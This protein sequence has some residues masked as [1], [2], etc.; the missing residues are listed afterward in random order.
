MADQLDSLLSE[1]FK[2]DV[3]LIKTLPKEVKS[4]MDAIS[5]ANESSKSVE[6]SRA[7]SLRD[8]KDGTRAL[9]EEEKKRLAL[10][11]EYT[12]QLSEAAKEEALLAVQVNEL[13]KANVEAAKAI[14]G[15]GKSSREAAAAKKA[16]REETR[17]LREEKKKEEQQRRYNIQ[18][19]KQEAKEI[20][21][22]NKYMV[23][24]AKAAE[25]NNDAFKKLGQE[26]KKLEVSA[27]QLGAIYGP[28]DQRFLDAAAAANLYK[29]RIN[30][31]NVALGDHRHN[32]GNYASGLVS[33][34]QLLR[35]MPNIGISVQTFIM[36]LSNQIGQVT[37][38]IKKLRIQN[39]EL[40]A[41]GKAAIPVWKSFLSSLMSWQTAIMIAATAVIAYREEI[42]DFFSEM[43]KGKKAI[44]SVASAMESLTKSE[45]AFVEASKQLADLTENVRLAKDGLIDK[46]R[47]LRIYNEGLGK[48]MGNLTNFADLEKRITEAGPAYIQMMLMRAAAHQA[49]EEAAKKAFEAEQTRRKPLNEMGGFWSEIKDDL[50]GE[51][52]DRKA[53]DIS[54]QSAQR[55][56]RERIAKE[57]DDQ[58]NAL[59][60]IA[61]KFNKD[62]EV[63]AAKMKFDPLGG[64]GIEKAKKPKSNKAYERFVENWRITLKEL[65]NK[66]KNGEFDVDM[67]NGGDGIVLEAHIRLKESE[68]EQ[69]LKDIDNLL[70]QKLTAIH[71]KYNRGGFKTQEDYEKELLR[72]TTEYSLKR[73]GV[74]IENSK[75]MMALLDPQSEEYKAYYKKLGELDK[76]YQEEIVKGNKKTTAETQKE[77][78][79]RLN[80][81][82]DM[83][84][85]SMALNNEIQA[86]GD[87]FFQKKIEALEHEGE[88]IDK[89]LERELRSIRATTQAGTERDRLTRAAEAR[90]DAERKK[91]DAEV[92]RMKRRQAMF[93]RAA[94]IA[95]I[96][97]KTALA[98]VTALTEG[99]P[100]TKTF[101][102]IAAGV[103]GAAQLARAIATPLP[104]YAEGTQN[105]KGGRALIGEGGEKELVQEPGGKTWIADRPMI[106]NL[107][108]G[109]RVIPEHD[110]VA[111]GMGLLTPNLIG[112][113]TQ[114]QVSEIELSPKTVKAIGRAVSHSSKQSVN[115]Y[116]VDVYRLKHVKGRA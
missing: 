93:D 27:R 43:F 42:A 31:I 115:I 78:E 40:I 108:A 50:F 81:I 104:S 11:F 57:A 41:Q 79:T 99:D 102:A 36:S 80:R 19:E 38:D 10:Q 70:N 3:E 48:T 74:Q 85:A 89:N 56:R 18:L 49:L 62:A 58:K 71:E 30:E 20:A 46:D 61:D 110:L 29:N 63:I 4:L 13:K 84:G 69:E 77:L 94:N 8:V 101:R 88:L 55:R 33:T 60:D 54:R 72:V 15:V 37:D 12:H 67:L 83:I 22:L 26:H 16:E 7:K 45:G 52:K 95:E 98:V 73:L 68:V 23:E 116:G 2:K 32:V 28:Q 103:L 1:G 9:L 113:M 92:L 44:D 59:I 66:F 106:A 109:T 17:R 21:D 87:M 51:D 65:A 75:K 86:F 6:N 5:A 34:N 114:R 14:L 112:R 47:V 105:H 64:D 91:R 35:E 25:A 96:I 90:A 111:A 53:G 82:A 100:Y 107:P 97:G 39:Q 24:Q 76:Q